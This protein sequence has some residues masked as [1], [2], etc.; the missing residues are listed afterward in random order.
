MPQVRAQQRSPHPIDLLV[1]SFTLVGVTV[2][3]SES[4]GIPMA[5]FLA[6]A[7]AIP[8]ADPEADPRLFGAQSARAAI[9][10]VFEGFPLAP[11]NLPRLR[12]QYGLAS[13]R[14]TWPTIFEQRVPMILPMNPSTFTRPADW[15][16][17]I[18]LSDFIFLRR[19]D[20]PHSPAKKHLREDI[21][22]FL[23]TSRTAGRKLVVMTFSSMAVAR[24]RMLRVAVRML[25]ESRHD[26]S[27][28]YAGK[29]QPGTVPNTLALEANRLTSQGRFLEVE[30]ADFGA[31]FP[32]IDAFV[33]HGGLGTTV[34]ALRTRKPVA[35]TGIL[36]MDQRF[37]G[38]VVHQLGVGPEPV[39]VDA[40]YHTCVKYIDG[41]LD[42]ASAWAQAAGRLQM[43]EAGDDGIESNVRVFERLVGSGLMPIG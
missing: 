32:R 9:K 21:R 39:H 36:L 43:G 29:R 13:H 38:D 40:F 18:E 26:F 5:G 11:L 35:V 6:Q 2:L 24:A 23:E 30:S 31:L 28:L 42:P 1:C 34:E 7:A 19:P 10:A 41:A 12:R 16:A 8:S 37:W 22:T 33:V 25:T 4:V 14:P 17:H 15:G 20:E 3:I 27:L